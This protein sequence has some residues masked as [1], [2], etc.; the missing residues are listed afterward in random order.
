LAVAE[1]IN[2]VFSLIKRKDGETIASLE[3]IIEEYLIESGANTI[4]QRILKYEFRDDR[5]DGLCPALK[6]Y[7]TS[8]LCRR[9][10]RS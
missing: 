5:A 6:F 9:N 1:N 4:K 7:V 3:F 2:K 8:W 10:L